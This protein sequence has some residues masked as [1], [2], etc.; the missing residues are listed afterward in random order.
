M[1]AHRTKNVNLCE[2]GDRQDDDLT[3]FL[4]TSVMFDFQRDSRYDVQ[5][6]IT[7]GY[8]Q[9]KFPAVQKSNLLQSGF[10]SDQY[11]LVTFM[12]YMLANRS[13][14]NFISFRNLL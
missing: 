13:K 6:Y 8:D 7:A 14:R 3:P 2:L 9:A 1:L 12:A 11:Q 10:Q 4:P 5:Y